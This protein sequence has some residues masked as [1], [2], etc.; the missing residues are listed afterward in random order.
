MGSGHGRWARTGDR[1]FRLTFYSV[2]W[3]EGVVNGFHRVQSVITLSETGDEFTAHGHADFFDANWNVVF[4]TA[5]DGKGTRLETQVKLVAP[6]HR[7]VL[8]RLSKGLREQHPT[9]IPVSGRP[10]TGRLP[11]YNLIITGS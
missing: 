6:D 4:S 8:E 5:T 3:K 9:K 10:A 7:P 11:H 2:L 1:E